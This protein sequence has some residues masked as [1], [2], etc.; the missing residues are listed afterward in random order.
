MSAQGDGTHD[1]VSEKTLSLGDDPDQASIEQ[2][3]AEQ[4]DIEQDGT[5]QADA[6]QADIGQ[7][8]T[9]QTGAEQADIEQPARVTDAQASQ[10]ADS[11]D[12]LGEIACGGMG[13]VL[14]AHDRRLNRRVALKEMLRRDSRATRRFQREAL[15]TARLQ[16][17]AIVPVYEAG[18]WPDGKR[19]YSMKLVQGTPLDQ[20]IAQADTWSERMALV[21][22]L[23]AVTEALAYAHSRGV[24]HRDLKPANII[25]G[26][27]GETV[28]IDWGLAKFVDPAAGSHGDV[29]GDDSPVHAE[30]D[31]TAD[32]Y[33]ALTAVGAVMGTPVYMPPEQAHGQPADR[34]S[35]VYAL[36]AILYHLLSGRLPRTA[37]SLEKILE[38]VRSVPPK[39]LAEIAPSVPAELSAIVAKAM[40]DEPEG[41]YPSAEA[42]ADELRGFLTGQFEPAHESAARQPVAGWLRRHRGAALAAAVLTV[43]LVTLATV[44]ALRIIEQRDAA[45]RARDEA[46]Q[47]WVTAQS[48]IE[49][50]LL[51]ELRD[52]A[53]R[54]RDDPAVHEALGA[55]LLRLGD[56]HRAA[57]QLDKSRA[58]FQELAALATRWRQKQPDNQTFARLLQA[59]ATRLDALAR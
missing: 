35:D 36:G 50:Q 13:R 40:Y 7:S 59:S 10:G 34:R 51:V 52:L 45:E 48:L 28:V 5:E 17:P 39:P 57:G 49:N 1:P 31:D 22:N 53:S 8:G 9:E 55:S 19:Y 47:S 6:E 42:L 26:R 41:R 54:R 27:F 12:I 20:L 23:L 30:D 14:E 18:Q 38:R 56:F 33:S 3:D 37:D 11:Y 2:A 32:D 25:V 43:L 44:A 15:I 58:S 21:P 16:H 46:R 29:G 4:T 24:I